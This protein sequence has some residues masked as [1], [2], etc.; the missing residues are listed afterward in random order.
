MSAK[1]LSSLRK[2]NLI[3]RVRKRIKNFF[4]LEQWV[5]WIGPSTDHTSLS[6]KNFK[7]LL[8]PLDRFWA[9]PFLWEHNGEHYLFIEELL[10]STNLGRISC[11]KLDKNLDIESNQVILEKPYH[12]S[13]PFL[14]THED[15]L[16]MI[17]EAGKSNRI[18]VYKCTKFPYVWEFEQTLIDNI[19]ALDTTLIQSNGK[20]WMFA[21]IKEAGG[22]TWDT[23]NL[24]HAD[25]PLSTQWA[26]HPLNPIVKDVS[27]AR[28]A[29]RIFSYNGNLIR[30]S[31][32]CSVRYGYATNFNRITNLTE[33]AYTETPE[34]TFF[35]P[36]KGPVFATHTYNTDDRL[37]VIDAKQYRPRFWK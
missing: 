21:N 31:Q 36:K 35:P 2:P 19:H 27:S 25:H 20:W 14:F 16:Y 24:Y 6:W 5:L 29:G 11:L 8:P 12:L 37:A 3:S 34:T 7:P 17:P 28:P 30:P 10:Y 33:T 26:P 18:D 32:D 4:F 22:S 1:F 9:D 15:N 23:L 13:Y